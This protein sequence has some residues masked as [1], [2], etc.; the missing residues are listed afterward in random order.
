MSDLNLNYTETKRDSPL[1]R[2]FFLIFGI[3]AFF[4]GLGTLIYGIVSFENLSLLI[5]SI[6]NMVLGLMFFLMAIEHKVLYP[7]KYLKISPEGINY[8]LGMFYKQKNLKWEEVQEI[9]IKKGSVELKSEV[10]KYKLKMIH[11]PSSDE[12]RLKATFLEIAKAKE[13]KLG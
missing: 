7:E 6:P 13:I 8:K 1:K 11:F 2:R 4:I 12:K 5:A 9:S 10:S 3:I